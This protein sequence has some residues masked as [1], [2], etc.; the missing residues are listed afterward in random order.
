PALADPQSPAERDPETLRHR[1]VEARA[2]NATTAGDEACNKVRGAR[3]AGCAA[4]G[5]ESDNDCHNDDV[6]VATKAISS[7]PTPVAGGRA[8]SARP[9]DPRAAYRTD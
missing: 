7:F 5:D 9:P 3:G 8:R 6:D 4:G 1:V 2:A